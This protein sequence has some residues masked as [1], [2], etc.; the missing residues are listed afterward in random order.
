[1]RSFHGTASPAL[2]LLRDGQA[3]QG[4]H[5]ESGQEGLG[6]GESVGRAA[7]RFARAGPDRVSVHQTSDQ[8]TADLAPEDRL[9][10]VAADPLVEGDRLQHGEVG[11]FCRKLW[12]L[13]DVR[14]RIDGFRGLGHFRRWIV[15]SFKGASIPK[16]VVPFAVFFFVRYPVSYRDLD[17]ILREGSV[18]VDHAT[19]NR[20]VAE[21]G[22]A[23][24]GHG[25]GG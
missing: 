2:H 8:V 16:E 7:A 21:N 12:F 10:P 1:M 20:W 6:G 4:F 9:E 17:E 24:I 19:L 14:L 11:R 15:I 25:S 23:I 13:T 22:G 5:P 18:Q 3:A